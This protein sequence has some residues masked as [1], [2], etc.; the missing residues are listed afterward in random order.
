MNHELIPSA[1]AIASQTCSGVPGTSKL[2]SSRRGTS[3]ALG[4]IGFSSGFRVGGDDE[5]VR[6][7]VVV[8][9]AGG[10]IEHGRGQL[11][12]EGGAV[13][14]GAEADLSVDRHRR[15]ALARGRGPAVELSDLV[16]EPRGQ[17]DEVAGRQPVGRS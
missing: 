6:P 4:F 1:V 11:V 12:G 16:Y 3:G 5:A 13:L 14:G 15:Q 7:P 2:R 9:V 10:E 8:V 17:G